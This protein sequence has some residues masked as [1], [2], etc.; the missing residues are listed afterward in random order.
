[1]NAQTQIPFLDFPKSDISIEWKSLFNGEIVSEIIM[2]S[3]TVNYVLEDQQTEGEDANLDSWTKA[4]TDL[5]PIKINHFEVHNGTLKFL[6]VT[7]EPKIDLYLEALILTA[8]NLRNVVEKP[9][10]LPSPFS[11]TATSIGQGKMTLNGHINLIK[12]V[13]DMDL[14]FA[15]ENTDATALND[16]TKHY[17]NIDFEKGNFNLYSEMAIADGHLKGYVKPLLKN[18]VLIGKDD[19]FLETVWEGFVGFFKFVLKNQKTD[20]LATKVPLEGDLN[21]VEAGAWRTFI[22]ILSNAWVEA[23]KGVVD[24]EI[25]FKDAFKGSKTDK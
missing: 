2:S 1:V 24:D 8:D 25:E 10:T 15:L 9:H 21:N 19:N 14:E 17:A 4:L 11:A 18:S 13:P 20:T 3:P 6:E 16:L 22:N 12:D 7:S 23:F 5:V